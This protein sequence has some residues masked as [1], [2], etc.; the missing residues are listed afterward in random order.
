[1]NKKNKKKLMMKEFLYMNFQFKTMIQKINLNKI[2][3][4]MIKILKINK[5]INPKEWVY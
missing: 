2:F 1:M 5:T 3:K 4:M